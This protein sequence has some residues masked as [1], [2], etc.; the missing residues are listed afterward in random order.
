MER[1]QR[2]IFPTP[3][4]MEESS[5]SIKIRYIFCQCYQIELP[6]GTTIITDPFISGGVDDFMIDQLEKVDYIILN[7]T[8]F[9]H[10]MDTGNVWE[11]FHGRIICQKEVAMEVAHFFDIPY[12]SI[13]AVSEGCTYY[14]P[15]FTIKTYHG[16]HDNRKAREGTDKRPSE[17]QD[18]TLKRFGIEGHKILDNMGAVFM[19]NWVLTTPNNFKIAFHAGQD[20]QDFAAHMREEKPNIMI[21]HR[22]RTYTPEEYAKQ[23]EDAGVQYIF[24]WHHSNA[25]TTGED[26]NAYIENVNE[27][28]KAHHSPARAF[29]PDPYRWYKVYLGIKGL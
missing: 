17:Q 26:L 7:H 3:Y 28:L 5:E 25:L 6:D 29:N 18:T 8:H 12:S 24:P 21:R 20:Y 1:K 23:C 14:F 19:L 11:K 27:V 9:D 10:D 2:A 13:Y 4:K 22:I 15:Q 16:L